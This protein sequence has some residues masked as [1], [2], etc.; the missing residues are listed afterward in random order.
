MVNLPIK[1]KGTGKT[2]E[3]EF[4]PKEAL[5]KMVGVSIPENANEFY[6]PI[7]AWLD[8]LV[9]AAPQ[10]T[11]RVEIKLK[12]F[13]ITSSRILLTIFKKIEKL[14]DA[15]IY[16]YYEDNDT[17]EMGSEYSTMLVIPVVLIKIE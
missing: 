16:W 4:R 3:M 7:L 17:Y 2:P 8:T 5:I 9:S 13:S 1:I 6:A 15:T 14:P 12:Y 11:I 10:E